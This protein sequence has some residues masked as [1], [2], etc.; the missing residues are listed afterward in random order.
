MGHTGLVSE[1]LTYI[2]NLRGGASA[3]QQPLYKQLDAAGS[4]AAIRFVTLADF[5]DNLDTCQRLYALVQQGVLD[6]PG[7]QGGF[8]PLEVFG[9]RIF[10]PSYYQE[11]DTQVLALASGERG[12]EQWVGLSSLRKTNTDGQSSFGLTVVLPQYRGQGVATQL[13]RRAI[14]LAVARGDQVI[15]TEVH[16]SNLAMRAV[17]ARL[18]F[19]LK[20]E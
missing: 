13:K 14:A 1:N 8:V 9:E 6:T 19:Q 12:G 3:S 17:N 5:P 15:T 20:S 16:P 2:L 11:A 10:G 18:G 4:A 7:H